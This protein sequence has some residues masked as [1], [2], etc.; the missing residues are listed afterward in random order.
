[1]LPLNQEALAPIP[2]PRLAAD[3]SVPEHVQRYIERTKKSSS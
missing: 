1:V 2:D 3:I